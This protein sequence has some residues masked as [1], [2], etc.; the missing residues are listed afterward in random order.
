VENTANIQSLK[1]VFELLRR[2]T[3]LEL[4]RQVRAQS[5]TALLAETV[6]R[7]ARWFSGRPH[8]NF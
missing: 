5:K 2:V 8:G 7:E 1:G 3:R 6:L 4:A